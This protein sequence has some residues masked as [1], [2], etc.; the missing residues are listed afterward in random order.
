[1]KY[2]ILAWG[3]PGQY[4][5]T[6]WEVLWWGTNKREA[7]RRFKDYQYDGMEVQLVIVSILAKQ[8]N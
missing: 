1:M 8:V 3:D 7:F 2:L 5:K 4:G 6:E